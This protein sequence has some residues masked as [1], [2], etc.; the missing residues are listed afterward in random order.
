MFV[1]AIIAPGRL[2]R[3]A[4]TRIAAMEVGAPV[5]RISAQFGHR[6]IATMHAQPHTETGAFIDLD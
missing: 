3:Q 2:F 5:H 6:S 1:L 4:A